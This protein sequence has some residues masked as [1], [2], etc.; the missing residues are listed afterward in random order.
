MRIYTTHCILYHSVY[1]FTK[2]TTIRSQYNYKMTTTV[3]DTKVVPTKRW[4]TN[5]FKTSVS[6][7]WPMSMYH[8][9]IETNDTQMLF[10]DAANEGCLSVVRFMVEK[11]I[12]VD[13][14]KP[15][16]NWTALTA[17]CAAHAYTKTLPVIRYLLEDAGADATLTHE[18]NPTKTTLRCLFTNCMYGTGA[19]LGHPA[20]QQITMLLLKHGCPRLSPK[21]V[22]SK[23]S[24]FEDEYGT[25]VGEVLEPK[26]KRWLN[27]LYNPITLYESTVQEM[28][29]VARVCTEI[30]TKRKREDEACN[31]K[32]KWEDHL[33]E[34]LR[35]S[36]DVHT[37]YV[38]GR[39]DLL[40]N[41]D[42]RREDEESRAERKREDVKRRHE[43]EHEDAKKRCKRSCED[44][45]VDP[46]CAICLEHTPNTM[47]LPCMH[48]VVCSMCSPKLQG[49][50]DAKTCVRCRC[51]IN[52]I[53]VV[54]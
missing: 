26:K 23:R 20:L 42:R 50:N 34:C 33:R 21:F 37:M 48:M 35:E 49:T 54:P 24:D 14:N 31:T 18:K 3:T 9:G 16:E 41:S 15:Y 52:E 10:I 19:K 1:R 40:V 32:R 12:I 46:R 51:K 39:H 30:N 5:L 45:N 29:R 6:K 28:D 44:A 53:L 47:V 43:R 22:K 13:V 7:P 4:W 2:T 27:N 8:G 38:R 11:N 17:T 25:I 36:H